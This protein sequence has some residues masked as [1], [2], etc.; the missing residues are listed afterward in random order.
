M[1]SGKATE[2]LTGISIEGNFNDFY[3][4]V[5]SIHR[6]LGFQNGYDD[7][8]WGVKNRLLG[9]CYDIRHAS[10]GD[11]DIVLVD[12][13][14]TEDMMKW[15]SM[16]LPKQEVR[17]SVDIILTEAVFVAL[18][19]PEIY[20]FSR[21]HY[22]RLGRKK[23]TKGEQQ[24]TP[25]YSEYLKD[26]SIINGLVVEILGV[27]GEIISD[28]ELEKIVRFIEDDDRDLF[29]NYATQYVD[30]CNIEYLKASP[31]KRK[32][33]IKYIT[34]RFIEPPQSYAIMK[35]E[36]ECS[37]KEYGCSIYEL[38]DPKLEYPDEIIW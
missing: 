4:L 25:K 30:K 24:F 15:H 19:V 38:C 28:D 32:D 35:D 31:E 16:A 13:G 17:F 18:S 26:K 14:V 5:G 36:L 21:L 7:D 2:N 33:K 29:K 11:R 20:I 10:M 6:M 8:Y 9:L 23:K 1:I 22:G 27:L 12:N 34:K 3:E 37:A